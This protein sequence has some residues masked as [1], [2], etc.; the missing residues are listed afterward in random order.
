MFGLDMDT[1]EDKR[2]DKKGKG[3]AV[4]EE[5]GKG[6]KGRDGARKRTSHSSSSVHTLTPKLVLTS[7]FE[8]KVK[9]GFV[10][11]TSIFT[12]PYYPNQVW[13]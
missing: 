12:F 3:R 6:K 5:K 7:S 11:T 1:G 2:E 10:E 13:N 9:E 8:K 4:D